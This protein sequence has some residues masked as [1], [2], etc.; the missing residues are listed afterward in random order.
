MINGLLG[1][2]G[3]LT[4]AAL[5]GWGN[6]DG[7]SQ[8]GKAIG[9]SLLN[10]AWVVISILL[11]VEN[12]IAFIIVLVAYP[13]ILVLFGVRNRRRG[14]TSF[15]GDKIVDPTANFS[16]EKKERIIKKYVSSEVLEQCELL[17]GTSDLLD[18]YLEKQVNAKK[19]TFEQS[20]ILYNKFNS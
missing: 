8:N 18:D 11:Y 7:G 3:Y 13:A 1:M 17:R 16:E 15:T 19:I 2:S 6:F 4:L 9:Y 5:Y 12:I 14:I 20:V 10:M